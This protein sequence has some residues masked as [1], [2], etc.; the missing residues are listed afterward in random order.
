[1]LSFPACCVEVVLIACPTFTWRSVIHFYRNFQRLFSHDE[2]HQLVGNSCGGSISGGSST[3]AGVHCGLITFHLARYRHNSRLYLCRTDPL[4][5]VDLGYEH[6]SIDLRVLQWKRPVVRLEYYVLAAKGHA[7]N[8]DRIFQYTDNPLERSTGRPIKV[9]RYPP[10]LRAWRTQD[11]TEVAANELG[12]SILNCNLFIYL[13]FDLRSIS[14]DTLRAGEEYE[15]ANSKLD[16]KYY[17]VDAG[18]PDA[19]RIFNMLLGST[20]G[21]SAGYKS[22]GWTYRLTKHI[23]SV[24][25][26]SSVSSW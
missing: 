13:I 26:R 9:N 1:M 20:I 25:K 6:Y 19:A 23:R 12:D 16:I 2:P 8:L 7:L 4:L 14:V 18:I 3:R 11:V 22:D 17:P 10:I 21:M 15:Q 24:K 5:P